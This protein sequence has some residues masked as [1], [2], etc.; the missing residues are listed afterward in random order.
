MAGNVGRMSMKHI[1]EAIQSDA[2]GDDIAN[3]PI[4]E[5]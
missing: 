4:P 1:L 5:S 3:L 2:S